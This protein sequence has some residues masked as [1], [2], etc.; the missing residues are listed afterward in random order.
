MS[1]LTPH[2]KHPTFFKVLNAVTGF[3]SNLMVESSPLN[4]SEKRRRLC[5]KASLSIGTLLDPL[6]CGWTI[7]L[8]KKYCWPARLHNIGLFYACFS[9]SCLSCVLAS[10]CCFATQKLLFNIYFIIFSFLIWHHGPKAVEAE[11]EGRSGAGP[12]IEDERSA[13][14]ATVMLNIKITQYLQNQKK[15][16]KEKCVCH[17]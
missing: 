10:K 15:N 8:K 1:Q 12:K 17:I 5:R 2:K 4:V 16:V 13:S 9:S 3:F 14:S 7:P 11:H 6:F